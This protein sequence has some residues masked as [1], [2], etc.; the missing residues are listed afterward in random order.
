MNSLDALEKPVFDDMRAM[1]SKEEATASVWGESD[2]RDRKE[3]QTPCVS[4]A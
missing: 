2:L 3:T 4:P 1:K